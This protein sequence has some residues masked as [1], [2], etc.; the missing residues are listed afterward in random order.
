MKHLIFCLTILLCSIAAQGLSSDDG[1]FKYEVKS[2]T[3][4]IIK[5]DEVFS[6]ET[7]YPQ[8]GRTIIVT[9]E[10]ITVNIEKSNTKLLFYIKNWEFNEQGVLEYYTKHSLSDDTV[11]VLVER[12]DNAIFTFSFINLKEKECYIYKTEYFE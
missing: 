11:V 10:D 6:G 5:D 8:D 1:I 3:H 9:E 2:I 12:G 4:C 7:T